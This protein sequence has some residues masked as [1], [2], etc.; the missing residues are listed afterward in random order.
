[1]N[2]DISWS[3]FFVQYPIQDIKNKLR[4]VLLNNTVRMYNGGQRLVQAPWMQ[5]D[6]ILAT[7][8]LENDFCQWQICQQIPFPTS[9]L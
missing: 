4:H 2:H 9:K 3:N 5:D 8:I 6:N 7:Q 1:M